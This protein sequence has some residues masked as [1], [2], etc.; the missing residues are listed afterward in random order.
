MDLVRQ[1]KLVSAAQAR[2]GAPGAKDYMALY[3][4]PQDEMDADP[5]LKQNT[6][7]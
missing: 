1:G 2:G 6:G 4:I 5:N 7:Y 3:P